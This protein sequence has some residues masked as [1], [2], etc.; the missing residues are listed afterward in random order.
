MPVE[1]AGAEDQRTGGE[2]TQA[3]AEK[4]GCVEPVGQQRG[5]KTAGE[6]GLRLL[7]TGATWSSTGKK[8]VCVCVCLRV[9]DSKSDLREIQHGGYLYG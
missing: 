7:R 2:H 4:A 6:N 5:Q 1:G 3:W 9:S 8:N